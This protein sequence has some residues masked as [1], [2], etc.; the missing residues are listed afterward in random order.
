MPYRGIL[1]A[2]LGRSQECRVRV[3]IDYSEADP[4]PVIL[5]SDMSS[6]NVECPT[7]RIEYM[8]STVLSL[9]EGLCH[10]DTAHEPLLLYHRPLAGDDFY[11]IVYLR[12]SQATEDAGI[13]CVPGWNL[14]SP[15]MR[16]V[17]LATVRILTEGIA[18][19]CSEDV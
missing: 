4:Q 11:S 15:I 18:Q 2:R 12:T 14:G 13:L 1:D 9:L 10:P 5:M 3:Y 8:T 17:S 19:Y 16:P 7:H 6:V